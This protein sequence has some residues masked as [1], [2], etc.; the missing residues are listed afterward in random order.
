[1]DLR[2]FVQAADFAP[3]I[4]AVAETALHRQLTSSEAE[5]RSAG[6]TKVAQ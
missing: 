1:M 4:S 3:A 2:L 6:T 5:W